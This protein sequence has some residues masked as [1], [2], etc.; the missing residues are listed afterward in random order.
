MTIRSTYLLVIVAK[1]L[2]RKTLANIIID[3]SKENKV[4]VLAE[5]RNKDIA[6]N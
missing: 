5:N 1:D 4:S 6:N 3:I 2:L